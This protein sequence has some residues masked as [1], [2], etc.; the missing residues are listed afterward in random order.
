MNAADTHGTFI[1]SNTNA[2]NKRNGSLPAEILDRTKNNNFI[3]PSISPNETRNLPNQ[4]FGGQQ[5]PDVAAM[6]GPGQVRLFLRRMGHIKE[7]MEKDLEYMRISRS[8]ANKYAPKGGA[9]LV[10]DEKARREELEQYQS[11]NNLRFD[12]SS[13]LLNAIQSKSI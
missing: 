3:L 10:K 2:F 7:K 4:T 1:A 9:K 12:P 11:A 6:A 8:N 5:S 13:A